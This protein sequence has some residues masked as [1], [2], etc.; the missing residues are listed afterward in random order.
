LSLNI[1]PL[2]KIQ[3]IQLKECIMKTK[4][5]FRQMIIRRLAISLPTL[6]M[7]F[8]ANAQVVPPPDRWPTWNDENQDKTLSPYFFIQSD[9]PSTDRLPLKETRA[10]VNIAGVIADVTITQ[11]YENEGQ[12]VLEAIYVFPASTRAAVYSMTMTIGERE[13]IAIIQEKQKARESYEQAKEE[14]RSASLLEQ[15][16]PNVFQMNVA[17]ILPGRYKS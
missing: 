9:D 6:L 11:T 3:S 1:K 2:N 4:H 7:I 12:N 13:I 10:D 8:F 15:M 5:N 16:R 17:N 14:G